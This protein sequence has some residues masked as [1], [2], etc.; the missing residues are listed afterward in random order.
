MCCYPPQVG[1]EAYDACDISPESTIVEWSR[2]SVSTSA[3]VPHLSPG[4][5]H[6][7]CGV[8]GHCSAGMRLRVV[9]HALA[10][11]PP[12]D[13]PVP[14]HCG[15][16]ACAFGY[17]SVDTPTLASVNVSGRPVYSR[18]CTHACT[19]KQVNGLFDWALSFMYVYV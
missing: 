12:L 17:G 19:G 2:P 10:P 18:A 6:F 7:I 14:A 5:Y 11:V 8:A 4:S 13:R 15:P 1:P 3:L 16:G 9:V